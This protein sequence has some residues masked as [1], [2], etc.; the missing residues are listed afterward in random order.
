MP[1]I[2]LAKRLKV[3]DKYELIT[4]CYSAP[5]SHTTIKVYTNLARVF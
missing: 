2:C 5:E 4:V 3:R 1:L